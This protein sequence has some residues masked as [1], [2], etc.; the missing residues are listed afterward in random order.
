M[1]DDH[2][3]GYDEGDGE[4]AGHSKKVVM[5]AVDAGRT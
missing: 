3:E 1:S 4:C 2:E 5:T